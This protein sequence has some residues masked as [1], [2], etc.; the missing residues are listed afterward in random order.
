VVVFRG[1]EDVAVKAGDL[2]APAQ[3][4]F[5]LRRRNV[6]RHLFLEERHGIIAEIDNLEI[7]V[8]ALLRD[9]EQ[10]VRR[11]FAEPPGTGCADDDADFGS[12]LHSRFPR[13]LR[14][15]SHHVVVTAVGARSHFFRSDLPASK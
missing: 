5:V 3:C 15:V 6:Q 9:I 12:F 14:L 13:H 7:G 1:D 10:P 11:D 2:L 4:D 8:I